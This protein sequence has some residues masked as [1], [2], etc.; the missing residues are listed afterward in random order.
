[1][2]LS[3]A[4]DESGKYG[5]SEHVVFAGFIARQDKWQEFTHE[6]NV[7]LLKDLPRVEGRLPVLHMVELNRKHKRAKEREEKRR[8]ESLVADLARLI[9]KFALEGFANTITMAEFTLLDQD[10]RKRYKDPFYYAFE[11]GVKSISKCEALGPHDN[12]MLICDDSEEYSSQCLESYRRIKRLE[13]EIMKRVPCIT[14][15]DDTQYAPLQA[16]DLYA[17]CCRA[18][19][20]RTDDGLW[21]EPLRIIHGEFSD[22]VRTDILLNQ[23]EV[24]HGSPEMISLPHRPA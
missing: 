7:R 2:T 8:V 4:F 19:R 5:D 17:Y 11:A 23:N 12:V 9:C 3:A 20:S 24:E 13:P 6:W 15:G 1:M 10:Q 22:H 18:N 21:V 14:F 16:A